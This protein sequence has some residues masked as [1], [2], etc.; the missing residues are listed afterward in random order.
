[1]VMKFTNKFKLV[2]TIGLCAVLASLAT[3]CTRV[4]TGTVGVIKHWN[5]QFSEQSADVG[6]HMTILESIYPFVVR[7]IPVQ[8]E[9]LKP[10]TKNNGS[11]LS[12]LDVSIQYSVNPSKVPT[13]AIKYR[14]M[15]Q[16]R[17]CIKA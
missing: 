3:G 1:M 10:Q 15:H 11:I 12:D 14:S 7:E 13:L 2:K 6:M 8:L 4:E 17:N 16:D 5:G 9:D